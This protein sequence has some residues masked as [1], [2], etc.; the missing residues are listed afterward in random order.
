MLSRAT[1]LCRQAAEMSETMV[2]KMAGGTT[3][4]TKI[5]KIE[6]FR[7]FVL[8]AHKVI[9]FIEKSSS[10]FPNIGYLKVYVSMCLWYLSL[11]SSN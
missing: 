9:T 5:I 4:S 7:L 11:I 6:G 10:M 8:S 3:T 1:V 2:H